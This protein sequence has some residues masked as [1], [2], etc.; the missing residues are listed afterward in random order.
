[1]GVVRAFL[2]HEDDVKL[3]WKSREAASKCG[4]VLGQVDDMT[5]ADYSNVIVATN[6]TTIS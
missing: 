1:M 2:P 5:P 6:L 3:C 4:D